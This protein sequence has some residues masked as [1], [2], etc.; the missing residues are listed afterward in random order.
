M[1][2]ISLF[3]RAVIALAAIGMML[4]APQLQAATAPAK[5]VRT[6]ASVL[7]IG[8]KSDGVF[9]GRV[10]DHTGTPSAKTEVTI[11]QGQQ[12]VAKAT[13]DVEGRFAVKG[14]KGGVYEVAS[15]KTVGT[16]R[17]WNETVA[18]PAAKEQALLV[19]GENGTRGKFGGM[20]G[21]EV[22]LAGLVLATLVVS[23][24]TLDE[25]NNSDDDDGPNFPNPGTP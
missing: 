8:L 2:Q 14:L 7:D 4:P 5:I 21:G 16:Y 20:G 13:T 18:P 10:V 24:I 25:V 11:R 1:K 23:L 6:D 17:V 12:V 22:L 19:L 3:K 15:G 9:A